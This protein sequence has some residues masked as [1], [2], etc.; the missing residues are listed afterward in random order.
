VE[1]ASARRRGT[2]LSS[3][4][5]FALLCL[6]SIA[7]P[8]GAHGAAPWPLCR[9]T[10][11]ISIH[12]VEPAAGHCPPETGDV[13]RTTTM[14]FCDTGLPGS[15]MF[16]NPEW[17][18]FGGYPVGNPP[19]ESNA[20]PPVVAVTCM[21]E[22]LPKQCDASSGNAPT[23]PAGLLGDPVD[24]TSG[25]LKLTPTDVDLGGGL[26]FKRHYVSTRTAVGPMG[27]GWRHGLEWSLQRTTVPTGIASVPP[28]T[29]LL[30][31]RPLR[32][33]AAFLNSIDGLSYITSPRQSGLIAVDPSG[34]V[35]YVDADGSQAEFDATDRLVAYHVPGEAPVTVTYGAG[36]AVT[37]SNGSQS[38]A[39]TIYASGHTNAGRIATVT[40][41]GETWSYGYDAS[42]NLT[43]VTGPDPST[44][45]ASD[46]ITLTYVY[47]SPAST[48]RIT[49]L[50]RTAGGSTTTLA[51]WTYVGN[52]LKVGTMDEPALEQPLTLTYQ[53]PE[54]NRLKATVKNSSNQTL[55]LFDS[56]NHILYEISNTTGPEA[57]VAGGP[58]VPVMYDSATVE[59]ITV[60]ASTTLTGRW[61][62]QVDPNGNVTL[63]ED[64][65]GKGRP[66]RI[67]EG[68]VD[69]LTAPGVFSPDDTYARLRE[70]TY[71][72]VLDET[73]SITEE[74][75]LTGNFDK[76]TTF[77]YDD[78]TDPSDDP[79]IPNEN[80]TQN[81][82]ARIESGHTLD[83]TG[84]EVPVE[85][86]TRYTYDGEGRILTEA[87]PRAENFTEYDYDP[88]SGYRTAVR[89]YL[90]GPASTYL[91]TAFADFDARGNPETV[92]DPNGRDTLFT[93]DTKGRVKTMKPPYTGGDSTITSTY[94]VDGNLVRVDFPPDSFSDP[95]F[96]RMGYD[97][98]NRMT[99]L[100][101]A[102]GNAIVYERTD[103]RVTR[104]ALYAG[105]V[106][107]TTRGT[108]KGDSTFGYD[109]A[110]RMIKAFNP[111]FGGGTVFTEYDHDAKGNATE[112]VDENGKEDTLLY[113]ALDRLTEIAQVRG[114]T[115][116]TAGYAYDP[117]GNVKEVTDPAGKT[118]KYLFDD[119]GRLV[120]VTSPN[121]GVTLYVYD[122]AGNLATK[123]EDFGGTG[124][125]PDTRTTASTGSRSSTSRPTP[126]G[127][128]AT[129]RAR[130]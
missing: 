93:Y 56:T 96:V 40:A 119:L 46:T 69:G 71:H 111:L 5:G 34:S 51:S 81:L 61:K 68:W 80:P 94:D 52:P 74:S 15:C 22:E 127:R 33:P 23:S 60:G 115:T 77:D 75:P 10:I 88:T 27:R 105:F 2:E 37:Y 108:L 47:T 31:R 114:G 103:G 14:L 25:A 39:L 126:T 110:G 122:D 48:G 50:D 16:T 113:D 63:F 112:I 102:Q 30:V 72:P 85:A 65:D 55:A 104:E 120:K 99:F 20:P 4:R 100:A 7:L 130:H 129:T 24:L 36:G 57:P 67:V 1:D 43:T 53:A 97:A 21:E 49:R 109:A 106:D 82:F 28:R 98:K 90:D 32:T 13:G 128:S 84:A 62:T 125:S 35:H 8:D 58:G 12:R 26:A 124:G 38:V 107:L 76:V 101:D 18:A 44:A 79:G 73:L 17:M 121:T 19:C 117:L 86:T 64:Y 123:V 89:R 59:T 29:V 87:G 118:T 92:T 42:Q 66:G 6:L 41:N 83:A 91:E 78:L 116:H 70:Y 45:S 95:Y 3:A 11:G 9:D 54:P